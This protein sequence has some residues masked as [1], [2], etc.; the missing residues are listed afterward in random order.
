MA[1]EVKE[2]LSG[3]RQMISSNMTYQSNHTQSF[4]VKDEKI[5][6]LAEFFA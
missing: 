5:N 4:E 1:T 3:N 6:S 2:Y